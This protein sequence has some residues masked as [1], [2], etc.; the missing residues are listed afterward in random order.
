MKAVWG[1]KYID[2]IEKV[3]D[4][5]QM[6][7]VF[8]PSKKFISQDCRHFTKAGAQYFAQLFENK[9]ASIFDNAKNGF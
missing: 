6:V 1:D 3:I 9:L 5:N 4:E 8:A 7:P 2:Y